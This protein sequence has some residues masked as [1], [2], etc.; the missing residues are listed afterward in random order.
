M[1]NSASRRLFAVTTLR[2]RPAVICL[3]L[4]SLEGAPAFAQGRVFPFQTGPTGVIVHSQFGG[5]IFGFDI[6]QNGSEGLLTEATTLSGGRVL[7]AVETFDQATGK[8]MKVVTKTTTMDDFLTLG[9]VGN[10]VGLVEREHVQGFL[11]ITRSFKTLNPLSSNRF[12]GSW[13]PPL[14]K[15]DLII[16]VS[17][18]Q[19]VS[20]SAVLAYHNVGA[21]QRFVFGTDVGANTFSPQ[22]NLQDPTFASNPQIAYDAI[23][24]TAVVAASDGTVGGPAPK[25]AL[26]NLATGQV[27]V[28]NGILGPA[29]FHQGF[30]NGLAVDA[31]D[32]IAVTT[33]EIDFRVEFYDLTTHNGFSVVLPGATGQ[34]QSGSDVAYDAVNKLFLVAQSVSSTGS[35]SSIHVYDIQGNLVESL[36]GFNFSNSFNV[37]PTHIGLNPAIRTGYVDG[38]AADVSQLQAFS[39]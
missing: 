14:Q 11:N 24:N 28:F 22:I 5:Q 34:L 20:R 37:V 19:G 18:N 33:T 2:L 1:H 21:G 8:I 32:Q 39:Y 36:N 29:P 26:A 16:S 31:D 38:P 6:D 10:Q 35:G 12:T 13:T 9:V 4:L 27:T 23:Q 25:I 7:A 30:I 3:L 15:N 17:R